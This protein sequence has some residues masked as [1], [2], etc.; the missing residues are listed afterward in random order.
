MKKIFFLT[1]TLLCLSGMQAQG[2]GIGI[3]GGYLTELDGI[4]GSADLIYEFDDKWGVSS[5]FTFAAKD[6]TGVRAKWTIFDLNGRYNVIEE[7]YL[8]AG[9][10][11]LSVNLR[12]LGL[13]GG[14]PTGGT[15][16]STASDYGINAGTGYKYNVVDN[17]NIFAE[18]KYVIFDTG[19]LHARLGI[20]FDL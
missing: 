16:T 17:I 1:I 4:G 2:F 11:Y 12:E 15:R 9:G 19:Y 5:T 20:L 3:S 8:I 6:D 10:E 13:G 18:V 14:N 7:L